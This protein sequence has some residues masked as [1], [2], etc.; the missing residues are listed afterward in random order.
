M[1]TQ[2]TPLF[3]KVSTSVKPQDFFLQKKSWV[4]FSKEWPDTHKWAK[5]KVFEVTNE[6]IIVNYAESYVLPGSDYKDIELSNST[7]GKKLYPENESILYQIAVG[8]KKGDYVTHIYIPKDRY[9]YSLGYSSMY[10]DITDASKL[11]LGAKTSVESSPE[12]PLINFYI[13]KDMPAF[14]LRFYV[15]GGVD[16]E[17]CTTQF[18][19]N[20]CELKE[21]TEPTPD[22]TEKALL[23]RYYTELTGF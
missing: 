3:A 21:I 13:I 11:Y 5:G 17:K 6:P 2:L 9:V 23:L 20:K 12:Y 19:I 10:P 7:A 15:L 4:R 18:Y 8:F 22:Q 14:Y 1:I 16:Y